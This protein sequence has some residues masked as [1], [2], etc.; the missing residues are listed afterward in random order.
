[1]TKER[2]PGAAAREVRLAKIRSYGFSTCSDIGFLLGLID[3]F[4]T[5]S[6]EPVGEDIVERAVVVVLRSTEPPSA[7]ARN[8]ARSAGGW[9][10]CATLS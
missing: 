7:S 9:M 2:E 3:D 6:R 4:A 1:M 5:K 10:F 8:F